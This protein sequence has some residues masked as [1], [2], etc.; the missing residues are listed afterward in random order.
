MLTQPADEHAQ[1]PTYLGNV[2]MQQAGAVDQIQLESNV[3]LGLEFRDGTA[4]AV[5]KVQIFTARIATGSFCN[6]AG[7]R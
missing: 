1:Q 3:N 6:V 5:K 7:N 2:F 4:G